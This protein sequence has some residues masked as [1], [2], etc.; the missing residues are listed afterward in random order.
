MRQLLAG[1]L[2][3][4]VACGGD[5]ADGGNPDAGTPPRAEDLT[6]VLESVDCDYLVTCALVADGPTCDVATVYEDA[7]YDTLLAAL[8]DGTVIYD[9]AAA[10][11]CLAARAKLDC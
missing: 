5:K 1:C 6:D 8:A 11:R 2:A 10:A 4:I 3:A 7:S 9:A